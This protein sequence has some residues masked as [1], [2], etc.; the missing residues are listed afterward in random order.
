MRRYYRCGLSTTVNHFVEAGPSHK[1]WLSIAF[2]L[3]LAREIHLFFVYYVW[4]MK[5]VS[6]GTINSKKVLD[7]WCDCF[8]TWCAVCWT[9]IFLFSYV[10]PN[11]YVSPNLDGN[12]N[13]VWCSYHNLNV[14]YISG[15]SEWNFIFSTAM[16]G[17][18]ISIRLWYEQNVDTIL[19][20]RV[21]MYFFN[22]AL[23]GNIEP[24]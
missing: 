5:E 2:L 6:R 21:V 4:W 23:S 14:L 9:R 15:Q 3:S 13:S 19:P 20:T 24:V 16:A 1:N 12:I 18:I 8:I 7:Y 11:I 10:S 22:T 17:N